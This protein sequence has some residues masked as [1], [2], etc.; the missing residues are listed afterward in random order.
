MADTDTAT[1]EPTTTATTAEQQTATGATQTG[2]GMFVQPTTQPAVPT[3]ADVAAKTAAKATEPTASKTTA[4]PEQKDDGEKGKGSK[5]AVLADLAR[6]RDERQQAQQQLDAVLQA[7]GINQGK[8][9]DPEQLANDLAAQRAE[10]AVLRAGHGI[11]D[12]EALL[13]S[14][15]FTDSLAKVDVTDQ[16]AVKAHIEAFTAKNPRYA[17]TSGSGT[18]PGVR[19][20]AA[21]PTTASTETDWLRAAIRR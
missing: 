21:A 4:E 6:E 3:P 13:D 20:A 12:V 1:T 17:A 19:D 10:N 2:Q 5:E 16:A 18:T 7:L 14:K 8:D 11:A 15:R 9:T